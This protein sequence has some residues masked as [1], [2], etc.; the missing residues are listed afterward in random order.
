MEP[1]PG[2][3]K[4]TAVLAALPMVLFLAVLLLGILVAAFEALF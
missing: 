1:D 3:E 4:C 2:F